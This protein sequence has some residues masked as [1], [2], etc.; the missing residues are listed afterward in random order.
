[1][2]VKFFA[3]FQETRAERRR[4]LWRAAAWLKPQRWRLVAALA[5]VLGASLAAVMMPIVVGRVLIDH[6]LLPNAV[7]PVA[8]NGALDLGQVM[9]LDCLAA[10]TGLDPLSATIGLYAFWATC[11]AG[12]SHVFRTQATVATCKALDELRQALFRHI[13]HRPA[14]FFDRQSTAQLG[15]RLTHDIDA[16]NQMVVG[17]INLFGEAVPFL[18]ALCVMLALDIPL[19]LELLPLMLLLVIASRVFRRLVT[20]LYE[21]MRYHNGRINEHLHDNLTGTETVQ[22]FNRQTL[23]QIRWSGLVEEGLG[24]ERRAFRVEVRYYPFL[25]NLWNLAVAVILWFGVRHFQQGQISLGAVVLFV[26]YSELLFRPLIELGLQIDAILRARVASD[27]IFQVIDDPTALALPESPLLLPNRLKGA[28]NILGLD[29]AYPHEPQV[30]VLHDI[31]LSI[32][33][34][35]RVAVVG[36]TG[37]GKT[38]LARLLTRQYDVPVGKVLLDSQDIMRF[39]PQELRKRIGT[40]MQDI[41]LFPASVKDNI[42][43]GRQGVTTE[44]IRNAARAV[45]ALDFI[46]RL[47]EGLETLLSDRSAAISH[48]ERQLLALARLMVHAPDVV[49][50]DE[51]TALVDRETE[52]SVLLALERVMEG[53]TSVVIAHRLQT[54]RDAD[55]IVVLEAGR[56]R[57]QGTHDQLLKSDELYRRLWR[58]TEGDLPRSAEY[59]RSGNPS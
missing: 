34:G 29:F 24:L 6:I 41:H 43:M 52:A 54:V 58:E 42:S 15:V 37:S 38:T 55:R 27:R 53:R 17:L 20:P 21:R 56:I 28:I 31:E 5:A 26:S 23:N 51:A 14:A 49:V 12:L 16:L 48:G 13:V 32:L 1:M 2:N 47:P 8:D 4:S 36:P 11:S 57:A 40:V 25:E 7:G 19:T 50:L 10:T 33:P 18:I 39:D 9:V 44:Q 45:Q 22:L 30:R 46:E 59:T 3:E 35:E